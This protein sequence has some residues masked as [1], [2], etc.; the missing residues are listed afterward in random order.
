MSKAGFHAIAKNE[1]NSTYV[2]P[3]RI[4][5]KDKPLTARQQHHHKFMD[6]VQDKIDA[7]RWADDVEYLS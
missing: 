3:E 1:F 2:S 6:V 5:D 7:K 4:P